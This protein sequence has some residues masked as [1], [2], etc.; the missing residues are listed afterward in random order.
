M[1]SDFRRACV[2]VASQTSHNVFFRR[3][4][5]HTTSQDSRLRRVWNVLVQALR[6]IR[7]I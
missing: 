3:G 1:I 7:D 2:Y 5:T 6:S 4:R